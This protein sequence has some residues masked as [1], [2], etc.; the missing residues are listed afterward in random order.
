MNRRRFL[1]HLILNIAKIFDPNIIIAV[2]VSAEIAKNN[3][4]NVF[5]TLMQSIYIQGKVLDGENL[6]QADIIIRPDVGEIGAVDMDKAY[7]MVEKGFIAAKKNVKQIKIEIIN[8]TPEKYL[9]E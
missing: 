7:G 8:K 4:D 5:E 6:R 9:I 1:S 2:D 3:P